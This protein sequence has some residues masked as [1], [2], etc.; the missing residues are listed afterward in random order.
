MADAKHSA[1]AGAGAEISLRIGQ[2][3]HH[4]D[5]LD[6]RVTGIIRGLD[7]SDARGLT[8]TV[9]LD[10]PIVIASRAKGDRE[11]RINWQTIPAHELA[12]FDERDE[13]IAEMLAALVDLHAVACVTSDEHYEPIARASAVIAKATGSAS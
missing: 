4:G 2:R 8:A 13:L 5:Y 1:T 7:A 6:R 11:I 3:V 12:P 10:E 9:L